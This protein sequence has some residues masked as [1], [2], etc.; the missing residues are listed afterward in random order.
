MNFY[1]PPKKYKADDNDEYGQEAPKM[2]S[3]MM[4]T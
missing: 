2:S 4:G 1:K 3:L